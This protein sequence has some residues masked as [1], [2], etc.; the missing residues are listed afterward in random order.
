MRALYIL[1][2]SQTSPRNTHHPPTFC[3]LS[4]QP[5]IIFALLIFTGWRWPWWALS[6]SSQVDVSYRTT[7]LRKKKNAPPVADHGHR[8]MIGV[9]FLAHFSPLFFFLLF[10]LQLPAVRSEHASGNKNATLYMCV[11]LCG[12]KVLFFFCSLSS[13]A[14]RTRVC[15]LLSIFRCLPSLSI[16]F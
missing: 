13:I 6:S 4:S 1:C 14:H 11:Y 12:R 8:G 3:P 7:V 9:S 15:F 16:C 10:L 5:T 2:S